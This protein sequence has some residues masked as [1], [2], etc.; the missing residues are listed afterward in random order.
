LSNNVLLRF[1][2]NRYRKFFVTFDLDCADRIEKS[3][4]TLLLEKGKHYLPI[5]INAPGKKN[6]EGLLPE[7]IVNAVYGANA[8]LVQ[9][10]TAGTK[11]EQDS[12]KS[13]L[14][15]L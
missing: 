15:K 11:D 7:T 5:G 10:A 12:A 9:A 13:K 2:K 3:L 8:A 1:V 4:Q 14:K 6:I